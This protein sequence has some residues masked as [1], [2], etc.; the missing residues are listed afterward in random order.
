MNSLSSERRSIN[1][2]CNTFPHS[3]PWK[4]QNI[5]CKINNKQK[6]QTTVI[7]K[8]FFKSDSQDSGV[9]YIA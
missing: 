9:C 7:K 5:N 1:D 8:G 3:I 6:K 2:T 4:N